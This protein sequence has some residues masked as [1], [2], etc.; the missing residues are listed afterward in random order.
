MWW[1]KKYV[2][3]LLF[4]DLSTSS[5]QQ[6]VVLRPWS[7][8]PVVRQAEL[9]VHSLPRSYFSGFFVFFPPWDTDRYSQTP[10]SGV[11]QVWPYKKDWKP[12]QGHTFQRWRTEWTAATFGCRFLSRS[13]CNTCSKWNNN[14]TFFLPHLAYLTQI[15][16]CFW[17]IAVG[18]SVG[19]NLVTAC[20]TICF[21]PLSIRAEYCCEFILFGRNVK[22]ARW[23]LKD[24]F[25]PT[26]APRPALVISCFNC[27]LMMDFNCTPLIDFW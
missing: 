26:V 15:T 7:N 5:L 24:S 27:R 22:W 13:T 25:C 19:W 6:L 23:L 9:S 17:G 12:R 16:G 20:C 2:G 3:V 4:K 1:S 8:A 10:R 21:F 18:R 11:E 14:I